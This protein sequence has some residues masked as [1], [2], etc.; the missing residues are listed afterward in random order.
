VIL[1]I[2]LCNFSYW[3]SRY[4]LLALCAFSYW[5]VWCYLLLVCV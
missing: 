4:K 2:G 5:F 1:A 3:F